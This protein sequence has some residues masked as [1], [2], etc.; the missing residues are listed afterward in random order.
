MVLESVVA[1]HDM[2]LE[3]MTRVHV[4]KEIEVIISNIEQTA[5]LF[6]NDYDLE[7]KFNAATANL[8]NRMLDSNFSDQIMIMQLLRQYEIYQ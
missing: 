2:E 1:V 5:T 4:S 3:Y 7:F 8:I 6:F